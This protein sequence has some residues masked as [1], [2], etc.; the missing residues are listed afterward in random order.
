VWLCDA[1]P[2]HA[3]AVGSYAELAQRSGVAL[4][5]DFDPHKPFIDRYRWGCTRGGGTMQ[6]VPEVIDA[7]FDSGSMPFAQWHYPFDNR[8]QVARFYPADFIAEGV[9]QTRGWFYSLLA[10]ATGLGDALPN[11]EALGCGLSAL[12]DGASP[13]AQSPEPRALSP[14]PRAESREP[15]AAPYRAVVVNE[16]VLDAEGRKM[17]K[18][19]GNTV[20]PWQVIGKYGVDAVRLFLLSTSQV[21]VPKRFDEAGIS[22]ITGGFLNTLKN[23]YSG[24]FALYANFGWSPSER[25][26]A[27]A[28]RPAIDRWILSRLATVER[29]CDRRLG[30]YDAT[31]AARLVMDFVDEDLSKWYV[32]QSRSRFYDVDGEDNRAAFATLH[33]VLTVTCRL[34]APFAPFV[35]DW[36]HRQLTGE[37][38]HLASYVRQRV[39]DGRDESLEEAMAAVRTLATLGRAARED[40][41]VKVRQPLSRMVCVVPL[42]SDRAVRELV[43]LL[44][45]ELNVKGVEFA[46][47][48]DS[49]VTL[50]AK[51]NF[52]SLGK[53]F[54]KDTKLAAE[55]VMRLT[56]AHLLAFER[57][58]G[59]GVSVGSET[60][61]LDPDDLT[62][63]R[64]A[65]GDLLVKEGA[66][67]FA[68][69]DPTVT[70]ELRREGLARELVSR[71]QKLR[72]D[73]GLQVSDRI[74]LHL[75]GNPEVEVAARAFRA[76]IADEVL[77][78]DVRIG[79]DEGA[80]EGSHH[81]TQPV[82]LDGL[83]ASVALTRES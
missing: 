50:E 15:R 79:A 73:S 13:R 78:T 65:S 74:V 47:S 40:A 34:L 53:K 10:I 14:E 6:R 24:I 61:M 81:A 63:V 1:D 56:S 22:K 83:A 9:D 38:V 42:R 54:G 66:G 35:S 31:L 32:R 28:D 45:A 69:L 71:V 82:D 33:E 29:E 68:A 11:N 7:W 4:G 20:D 3:E 49:L 17:S 37:S 36:M 58:E 21:W 46:S 64:R 16:L 52:R 18:S 76:W 41:G 26:P 8:E 60:H 48:A 27:V 43:P 51:P 2:S 44:R 19:R 70:P 5:T 59:L 12:G 62:I 25:D 77:A 80:G 57:G 23:V 30:V 75:W 55:A 67:Y 72:R 39:E